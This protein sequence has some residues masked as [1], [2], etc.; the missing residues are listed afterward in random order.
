MVEA[1]ILKAIKAS[2]DKCE[3]G[4]IGYK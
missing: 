1:K 4:Y 3:P 2:C